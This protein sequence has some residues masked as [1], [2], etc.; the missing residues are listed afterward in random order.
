[1]EK[2]LFIWKYRLLDKND[3]AISLANLSQN[4]P[5]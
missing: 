4:F 5:N 1:M 2:Q 3:E